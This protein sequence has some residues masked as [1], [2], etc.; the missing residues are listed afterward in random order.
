[1]I[2]RPPRS[3]LFPY[4]T[5]FRSRSGTLLRHRC[6]RCGRC[7]RTVA[8]RLLPLSDRWRPVHT[9]GLRHGGVGR[10]GFHPRRCHGRP[11][12]RGRR[13]PH[14]SLLG[15]RMGPGGGFRNFSVGALAAPERNLREPT[16]M[17]RA[18]LLI[19]I[20]FLVLGLAAPLIVR[21]DYLFHVLFRVFLFAAL[22]LAWN[23]VGG[24]AGQLSLGHAA[25]FGA[26]AYGLA[27]FSKAAI[28][29]W[30][31]LLLGVLLAVLFAALIGAASFRVCR[32]YFT[33]ATIAFAEVLRVAAK[34]LAAVT[35]G[36]VGFQNSRP[37]LKTS[38]PAPFLAAVLLVA[39]PF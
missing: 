2:R 20:L 15:Q 11:G 19:A 18:Q 1:M 27:V 7:R 38:R 21:S 8:A 17:R 31:A 16:S 28:H 23:L 14:E 36:G 13:T 26:G 30:L 35:R 34:N 3:T 22:G 32:P 33:L 39:G 24:Y 5:L 4:T 10:H 12:V 25:Y 9:Q 6:R 37:F 29:P